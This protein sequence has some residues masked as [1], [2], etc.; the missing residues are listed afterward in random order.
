V[1]RATA[2]ITE[3]GG[4][5]HILPFNMPSELTVNSRNLFEYGLIAL[6]FTDFI[7]SVNAR[8]K[9]GT[10]L[11]GKIPEL[12]AALGVKN[13]L[14]PWPSKVFDRVWKI[15]FSDA[16]TMLEN[17]PQNLMFGDAAA[18]ADP[19]RMGFTPESRPYWG[20][21]APAIRNP[22]SAAALP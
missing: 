5:V 13:P 6:R 12:A 2:T 21:A 15:T 16:S 20:R 22:W 9:L 14:S 18:E 10:E 19:G 11:F 17:L 7:L 1:L 8:L 3:M 4:L